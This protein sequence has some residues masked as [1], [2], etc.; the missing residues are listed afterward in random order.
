MQLLSLSAKHDHLAKV[1]K[2]SDVAKSISEF[3]WNA[4]DADATEVFVELPRNVLGGIESIIIRDKGTGIRH[5]L[6]VE[7]FQKLGDS[8]KLNVRRTAIHG[9]QIHGKAGQ[10]RL[11]F[12]SMANNAHWLSTVKSDVGF[13]QI[14]IEING[15][16]LDKCSVSAPTKVDATE[17]GTIVYLTGL[18]GTFDWLASEAFRLELCAIFAPY[19]LQH[20][21]SIIHDGYK[22]DPSAISVCDYQVPRQ[23]IICPNRSVKDL[24]LRIIEWKAGV[25]SRKI[26]LG[27]EDG[28]VLGS[29]AANVPAPGFQFSAYACSQFFTEVNDAN[30]LEIDSLTDPDFARVMEYVR[31][32]IGDYFRS[33]QARK[34]AELIDE[35]KRAGVYPYTD[36]PKNDL[37]NKEREVFDIATHAVASYSGEFRK[38]DNPIKKIMLHLLREALANNPESISRILQ[39]V[40]RLPKSRQDEFSNLLEKTELGNI[41]SASTLVANRVVTLKVLSEI[42]FDPKYQKII[43][44]RGELDLLVRENLWIFGENYHITLS[45]AGLSQVVRRVAE[46]QNHVSAKK[47]RATKPDGKVGRVDA[48][49]GRVV[50]HSDPMSREYIL[51]ELKR[52]SLKL[53]RKEANQLE[54]YVNAL[55]HQPDFS[56]TRT[57][58]NFYLVATDYD[59]AVK[60]RISQRNRPFGV[61]LEGENYR[62][63]VKNWAEII[64]DNEARLKFIGDKLKLE[65]N[66]EEI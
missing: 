33:R 62:A 56:A 49:L 26:F 5:E 16:Q 29:Q 11:K 61:L 60:G 42:V 34:S 27:N 59:D 13:E 4:L 28:V 65:I 55:V 51:V 41:I 12:Y 18:T 14:Q 10:G 25:E 52:P 46:H 43:K 63:W 54:D 23:V 57:F 2:S 15:H 32:K 66:S 39:A 37:E 19:I 53:T 1:A 9:R 36:E 64:R 8:W 50:P 6:A 30:L 38:S 17:S 3:I 22:L 40:F 45:E 24:D 35:L 7:V 47:L 48:F 20:K 58:L 21:V 31:D 44:E